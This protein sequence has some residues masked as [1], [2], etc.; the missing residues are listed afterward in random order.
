MRRRLRPL[1][2]CLAA[3]LAAAG[4]LIPLPA[5]TSLADVV[6]AARRADDAA[7]AAAPWPDDAAWIVV[8]QGV[9]R[10]APDLA[11]ALATEPSA[12]HRH[13]FRPGEQ[14][15]LR[16]TMPFHPGRGVVA[17]RAAAAALGVTFRR[18]ARGETL[19]L[20]GSRRVVAAE[21][22]TISM[23]LAP[24]GATTTYTVPVVVDPDFDGPLLVAPAVADTLD[25]RR[26][27]I[28]GTADVHVAL[29]RPF[30]GARA[31][32]RAAIPE[33]GVDGDVEAVVPR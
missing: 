19:V 14:G 21:D 8:A 25:L 23:R 3:A 24:L 7:L 18:N 15:D 12:P 31:R 26:F 13:V 32:L 11:S 5:C 33:L 10:G 2:P 9:V 20:R 1:V 30:L 6:A 27:E 28:P 22:A 4:L 17:G 29:G 16:M